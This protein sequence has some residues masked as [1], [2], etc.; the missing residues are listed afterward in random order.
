VHRDV[1]RLAL[2]VSA[3][4][5][6]GVDVSQV[7]ELVHEANDRLS[8]CFDDSMSSIPIPLGVPTPKNRRALKALQELDRALLGLIAR[9]RSEPPRADFLGA[10][11]A[12]R[13]EQQ[14]PMS[15][16]QLRDE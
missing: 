11:L 10:L 4:S 1:S 6:F 3:E 5:L 7:E 13:D 14:G 9:R 16:Q 12:A 2:G 8:R 15:D